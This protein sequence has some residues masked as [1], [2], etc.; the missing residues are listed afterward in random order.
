M[1]KR[2]RR[3]YA[4]NV[5][6]SPTYADYVPA[7]TRDPKR[8]EVFSGRPGYVIPYLQKIGT[9]AA[10][11]VFAQISSEGSKEDLEDAADLFATTALGTAYHA[12]A[13]HHADKVMFRRV[14]LPLLYNPETDERMTQARLIEETHLQLHNAVKLASTVEE[15]AYEFPNQELIERGNVL[16]GRSL[17]QAAVSLAVIKDGITYLRLDEVEMQDEARMA[18]Q[19]AYQKSINL[20]DELGVRP[21]NAQFADPHSELMQHLSNNPKAVSQPVYTRLVREVAK[22]E[23]E[24]LRAA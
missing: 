8:L 1:D 16:V 3:E 23:D 13:Q 5:N 7:P 21:T 18:A 22:A 4:L 20:S 14:K 2:A 24:H 15:I 19:R 6:Q 12:F 9:I 11:Q 10:E 17:A